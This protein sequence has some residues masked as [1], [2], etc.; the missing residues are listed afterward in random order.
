MIIGLVCRAKLCHPDINKLNKWII[1]GFLLL[2][3]VY[4]AIRVNENKFIL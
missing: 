1:A 2:I 3:H 4:P